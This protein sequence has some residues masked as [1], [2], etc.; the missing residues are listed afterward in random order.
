MVGLYLNT[1][2]LRARVDPTAAFTDF[3]D[4]VRVDV[5]DGLSNQEAPFER[6]VDVLAPD[7][8]L[9]RSPL[10]QAMF[11]FQNT[12]RAEFTS[13]GLHAE[14]VHSPWR[15]AK[16]DLTLEV[17]EQPDGTLAG[18]L[19]YPVALFDRTTVERLAGHF[20]TLL[21]GIT[22]DPA[23]RVSDL[24]WL[25]VAE[26]EQLR[27]WSEHPADYPGGT[28]LDLLGD[29]GPLV[30]GDTTLTA[31]E[32]DALANRAAH[33][34]RSLGV[35]PEAV[36]GVRLERGVELVVAL[37]GVLKAGGAYLPLDPEY[38]EERLRFMVEDSGAELVLTRDFVA[39]T[40]TSGGPVESGVG[41][42]NAAYVIYTSGSTG[43]P[44]GVVVEHRAVVNR[45]RW[46]QS[47]YGLDVS[48]RV[49]QKTPFGFDVSVWEFFWTL[50]AGATLVVAKPGGHRDPVYLARTIVEQCVTTAHFV[51]SMLRVFLDQS[52]PVLPL[53]RV[54][55]SGEALPDDLAESFHRAVGCELHNLYGPTEAAVDV[56][57]VRCL[58]GEKVTIGR[59]V[60]NTRLHVVDDRFDETDGQGELMIAGVQLARGYLGRPALTAERFVPNPFADSPG[61]RLYHTGDLASWLPDGTID[62]LGR[63]DHQV[64]LHGNRVELG[65]VEAAL[66][67]H[68]GVRA[69]AVAVHDNRLVGYV[70]PVGAP[71]ADL[72]DHLA[73]TLPEV[74]IPVVW[75]VLDALPLTSSG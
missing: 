57:A 47:E 37:L 18:V 33:R 70:V 38:P 9:S 50:S 7:R 34:L 54:L 72:R 24:P 16:F 69:A 74:M 51:P 21:G 5:L 45:L 58:P 44:K 13:A 59:P 65:E 15:S 62:Y 63:I 42:G 20:R 26:V 41:P 68:P 32:L 43:R 40:G 2:V 49:L 36:V 27:R 1:L 67:T 64:K 25:T 48:D 66:F 6:L 30:V 55:C 17:T 52:L 19:E 28:L 29:L 12:E 8:D 75:T 14:P 4:R 3:L 39:G 56:T 23:A 31:A 61:E 53:R 46:A 35:G 73:V 11:V 60:D 22:D 10:F 71:P